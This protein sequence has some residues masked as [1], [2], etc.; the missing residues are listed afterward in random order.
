MPNCRAIAVV[1]PHTSITRST[2][3]ARR[4]TEERDELDNGGRAAEKLPTTPEIQQ[5][6]NSNET[7]GIKWRYRSY[8]LAYDAMQRNTDIIDAVAMAW[9][10]DRKYASAHLRYDRHLVPPAW[11]KTVAALGLT[12]ADG[13]ILLEAMKALPHS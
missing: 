2:V 8:A 3:R 10:V 13:R 4:A 11:A 5:L 1:P 7:Q 9:Q 12:E 6:I